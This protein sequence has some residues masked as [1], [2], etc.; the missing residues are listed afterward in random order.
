MEY[1]F[2]NSP[3]DHLRTIFLRDTSLIISF[4]GAK[5][6]YP[7]K[8]I[9]NVWLNN[10]G[11][12]CSPGE[13][14][15]TLN[16]IDQKPIYI[17]SKNYNE[18]G[19]VIEQSNFYNS[20][21]RVIHMHLGTNTSASFKFGT[22]PKAYITRVAIILMILAGCISSILYTDINPIILILPSVVGI[23]VTVCGLK[24]CITRFPKGYNPRNIPLNLL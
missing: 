4:D 21:V 19:E 9:S 16:I 1:T 18:K 15:C 23:F 7:Y 3:K 22:Q 10:P 13:F 14:S 2:K 8:D 6:E 5:Y 24:F 17:S 12:F 11:G 20:F